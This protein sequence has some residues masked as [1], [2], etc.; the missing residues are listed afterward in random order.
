MKLKRSISII[1]LL[2]FAAFMAHNMVPHHHHDG[3]FH[4]DEK[5]CCEHEHAEYPGAEDQQEDKHSG[6]CHAFNNLDF[7]KNTTL[8]AKSS[9]K[10]LKSL[11]LTGSIYHFCFTGN[12]D[13]VSPIYK[14]PC[15][16]PED[17]GSLALRGPPL[18]S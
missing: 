6:H 5:E 10:Q 4:A 18:L 17:P 14:P 7:E 8:K 3:E 9:T 16:E 15:L 12:T 1:L 11:V 13:L 2:I